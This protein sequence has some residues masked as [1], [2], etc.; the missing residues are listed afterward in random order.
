M[1]KSICS[2]EIAV[3]HPLEMLATLE[4]DAPHHSEWGS[5]EVV[6]VA[7]VEFAKYLLVPSGNLT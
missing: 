4:D 5:C 3:F 7:Q 6:G 2:G 1:D